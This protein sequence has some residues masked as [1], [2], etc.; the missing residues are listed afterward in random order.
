MLNFL[1]KDVDISNLSN[2][3]TSA[4]TKYYFEINDLNDL[5][6]LKSIYE[7][8][9]ENELKTLIVWS[10]TN[11]LFA[12]YEF[13]WVIIKNNLEWFEYDV[14]SKILTSFSNNKIS[15]IAKYLEINYNQSLWHRFIWLPWSIWGAVFWNAWCFWLE[16]ESNLSKVY[17]YDIKNDL[18]LNMEKKDILFSY[19]DSI[20][21]QTWNYFVIKA[22]FDLSILK[23]KYSSDVD[24]I[25]FREE[26]QPKWNS[27]W[28]FFKNPSKEFSAWK[29]I[30]LVW[31]KWF[32][33]NNAYFSDKHANFLMTK[34][35]NWDYK[36]LLFLIDLARKKVLE[37][38][39]FDL[40][41]EVRIIT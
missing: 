36:D 24:N 22:E 4:K 8:A 40:E 30:E 32:S 16:T 14:N 7:F 21:K 23:E 37:N 12:F 34:L 10:G 20:F 33:Y 2:Y 41:P 38:Y 27:C 28:S 9:K 18:F 1:K 11:L 26:I 29:L 35:D 25:K 5:K 17:A 39:W 13:D 6:N 3:K 19:R 15:D 31:L